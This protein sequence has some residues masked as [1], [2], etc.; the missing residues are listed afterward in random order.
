MNRREFLAS[1]PALGAAAG[2][3]QTPTRR[4]RAPDEDSFNP[5]VEILTG[6]IRNNVRELHRY[7]GSG[8]SRSSRTTPTG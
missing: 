3:A 5:W 1:A 4:L 6:A 8:S 2:I 7:S